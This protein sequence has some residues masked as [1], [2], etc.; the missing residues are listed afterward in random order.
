MELT[1]N[2]YFSE[3]ALDY[4]ESEVEERKRIFKYKLRELRD[5]DLRN[6]LIN[7]EVD[8]WKYSLLRNE[9]KRRELLKL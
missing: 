7:S 1:D 9:I 8:S 2:N 6:A 5:E 3:I 4:I